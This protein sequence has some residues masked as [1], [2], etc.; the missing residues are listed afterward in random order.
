MRHSTC[1]EFS[2]NDR[3]LAL[4]FSTYCSFVVARD[5]LACAWPATKHNTHI[6]QRNFIYERVAPRCTRSNIQREQQQSPTTIT[7]VAARTRPASSSYCWQSDASSKP[8]QCSTASKDPPLG[9]KVCRRQGLQHKFRTHPLMPSLLSRRL[10]PPAQP[11][12]RRHGHAG[13][14]CTPA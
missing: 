1:C 12:T 10:A 5:S 14:F 7:S 3:K 9:Y 4:L 6:H 11:P 13:A 8:Q 2:A